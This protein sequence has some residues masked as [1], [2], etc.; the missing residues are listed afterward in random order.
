M[1]K[2]FTQL[3]LIAGLMVVIDLSFGQLF[4]FILDNSPDG[5]YYKAKYTLEEA[6]EDIVIIGSS[7]GEINYV[8]HLFEEAFGLK[9]WNASRGGQGL[10][11]FR[12]VEQGILKRYAP[13]L[14]IL[15][16]EADILEHVPFYQEAGFLR[17]F[18]KG[19]PEIQPTLNKISPNEKWMLQSNLYAFNSSYYYLLRPFVF[20]NLDG[21]I[22]DH[23][24]KPS[25]GTWV[26]PGFPF[27][28]INSRK[29]LDAAAV[30]E[31]EALVKHFTE[32]GVQLVFSIAPNY[33]E[34][35]IMTSSLQHIQ[36]VAKQNSIP[37]FN[38]SADP[39]FVKNAREYIDIQHLNVEGANR[40]T[41]M[42]IDSIQERF[43]RLEIPLHAKVQRPL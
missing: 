18:Y 9:C 3:A 10:P 26:D 40:F 41:A 11:Y 33:G 13:K 12:A 43:P 24:W 19:H 21:K 29:A 27:E 37:L 6:K 8:P 4:G 38:F 34:K 15:N 5:R 28:T 32:E 16:L 23:G 36:A 14:V 17:V 20:H 31:F 30:E 2:L 35:T 42:L 22:S 7:R 39:T 1:N 25:H